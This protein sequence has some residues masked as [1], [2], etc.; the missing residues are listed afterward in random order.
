MKEGEFLL[1]R[2]L[3][4]VVTGVDKKKREIMIEVLHLKK[5]SANG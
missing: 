5:E 3:T 2:G 4:F 1:P